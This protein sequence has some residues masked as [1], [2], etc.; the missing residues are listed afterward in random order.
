MRYR[1]ARGEWVNRTSRTMG[2]TSSHGLEGDWNVES[3]S[4]ASTSVTRGEH[5]FLYDQNP[6]GDTQ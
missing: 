1:I 2:F 4:A 3:D 6:G 5:V